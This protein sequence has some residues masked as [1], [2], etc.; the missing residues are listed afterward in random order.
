MKPERLQNRIIWSGICVTCSLILACSPV[1]A[2]TGVQERGPTPAVATSESSTGLSNQHFLRQQVD[3][4]LANATVLDA[5]GRVVTGLD[6]SDF[7]I[8]ENGVEQEIS[9]FSSE[10]EP[11]SIGIV[12]DVSGSMKDKF[13]KS[14]LAVAQFLKT[15]N[16]QDE[17][18][19]VSFNSS[20]QLTSPFTGDIG[21]LQS[22]L[23]FILPKGMTALF[24]AVYLGLERM[25][26][27]QNRKRALLIISDG[28]DN[29]SR[30]TERDV[31]KVLEESDI[32][33]YAIG[34]YEP[35]GVCPTMEECQGPTLL[36]SLTHLSGGRAFR[37]DNIDQLPDIAEK[38][39]LE[40]RNQYVIGYHPSNRT[41][42]GKWRKIKV[43]L[44]PPRGLPPL[45]VYARS[46]YRAQKGAADR[47]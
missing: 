11:I 28:G 26:D 33:L 22:R 24:D 17:F 37:V 20:A 43:K 40:L 19:L 30:Y 6:A 12:L 13:E 27:A 9:T 31:R 29:H 21:E 44:H 47:H 38:I 5:Y 45:S 7:R 15:A 39:S 41:R 2:Q 34:I 14:R 18:F 35:F 36:D 8:F 3:L 4:V 10:D 23:M 25:N 32:Q 42:D 1:S 16:R 46:G